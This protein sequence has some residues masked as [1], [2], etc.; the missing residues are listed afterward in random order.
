MIGGPVTLRV[1][2]CDDRPL[3][4]DG[5]RL[6]LNHE[7]DIDVI[8]TTDS[9]AQ[10]LLLAREHL[11]HVVVTGLNLQQMSGLELVQRLG[12]AGLDP[13]PQIIVLTTDNTD[14]RLAEVLHAGVSGLLADDVSRDELTLAVRAVARGQAMLGPRAAERLMTWFRDHSAHTEDRVPMPEG[15]VLTPREREILM[16]TAQG[17]STED[18]AGKLYI[19]TTTVRTHLYRLRSKLQLRD[20]AQLVSFA[21]RAGIVAEEQG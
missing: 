4:L 5:L 11:P 7:Q 10:A 8:G 3:V 2:V 21:F 20:R 18:I 17:L 6:L 14:E 16:L 15:A 13:A 9:G 19:S 1:L 12:A